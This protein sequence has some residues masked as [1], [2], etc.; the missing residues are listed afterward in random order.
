MSQSFSC[1]ALLI[2]IF[3]LLTALPA[4]AHKLNVFSWADDKAIY[5]EAFFSGGRK[6]KNISVQVQD[7]ASH[8]VLLTTQTDD[9]G[10]FQFTPPQQAVQQQLDVLIIADSGDGHRGEWRL[11]AGEYLSVKKTEN[12]PPSGSEERQEQAAGTVV[13]IHTVRKIVRQELEKELAP[14]KRKLA[15]TQKKEVRLQDIIGG[16]GC[17]LGMAGILA[18]FRSKQ[19]EKKRASADG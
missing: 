4:H 3:F 1:K 7:V 16:I 9:K 2:I 17:I 6:A 10:N 11:D 14:I 15:E 18:W 12:A 13:D 8:T 19:K 5:G